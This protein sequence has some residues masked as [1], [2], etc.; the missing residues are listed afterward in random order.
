[1]F[2]FLIDSPGRI[3]VTL[4]SS[5]YRM[6]GL[7]EA[8]FGVVGAMLGGLGL[9]A[10]TMALWM[11][12]RWS[13]WAIYIVISAAVLGSL[14]G[15]S[16]GSLSIGIGA[17]AV[18]GIG[19]NLL[20]FFTSHYLNLLAPSETRA[21][22]LSFRS[23]AT[24]LTYGFFGW[25][26]AL[27]FVWSAGGVRPAPGSALEEE[28]LVRTLYWIPLVFLALLLPFFVVSRGVASMCECEQPS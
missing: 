2:G 1:M 21:T 19:F 28:T 15:L 4:N 5:I 23:L 27:F 12:R 24:S 3:I 20:G 16:M 18:L 9:V 17:M 10:P 7:R 14:F 8:L 22:V 26:Y 6:L 25:L 13:P 11:I